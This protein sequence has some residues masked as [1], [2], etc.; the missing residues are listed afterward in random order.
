MSMASLWAQSLWVQSHAIAALGLL[1]LTAAIFALPRGSRLHRVLG[2]TWVLG[3]ATVALSSFA[4]HDL[5]LIGPFSP[6]H[7]L[8]VYTLVNLALG[9][10]A[11]RSHRVAAHRQTMKAMTLAALIGAG[12][13]TLLPGRVMYQVLTGG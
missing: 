10:R 11:A 9:V 5:R 12:L 4:I 2:W 3:M 7:A 1:P 6:I 13:F 8:S